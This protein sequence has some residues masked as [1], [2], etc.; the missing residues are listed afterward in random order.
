MISKYLA[1]TLAAA[2]L[3]TGLTALPA[4]AATVAPTVGPSATPSSS[5]ATKSSEPNAPQENTTPTPEPLPTEI[6]AP[7]ALKETQ[8]TGQLQGVGFSLPKRNGI[9][10]RGTLSVNPEKPTREYRIESYDSISGRWFTYSRSI[11]DQQGNWTNSVKSTSDDVQILRI[12]VPEAD[13]AYGAYTGPAT[14]I[15]RTKDIPTVTPKS[16][17]DTVVSVP[18]EQKYFK[19]KIDKG[20][21][22]T[23]VQLQNKVGTKWVKISSLTTSSGIWE[24]QFRLPLGNKNSAD[25]TQGYRIALDSSTYFDGATSKQINVR[26]ENPNRYTGTAKKVYGYTGSRCP[27]VLIRMDGS[28]HKNGAWGRAEMTSDPGVIRISTQVPSKYLRDV[29][30]HECSHFI[31]YRTATNSN[32]AGW[33]DYKA[34]A[35]KL[36][37]TSGELGMER[38]NECMTATWGSHSYWTYGAT[39]KLCGQAKVN[40]FVQKSLKGQKVA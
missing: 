31:Q 4:Q 28:I 22:G 12:V 18:W 17:P 33:A 37:G 27:A 2:V 11:T 20:S 40:D 21:T 16:T 1:P 15:K 8:G 35:N 3:L 14:T 13:G 7:V 38:V 19:F 36:M 9:A 6:P 29:S 23:Q 32:N 39:A 25:T 10:I 30:L 26:W 5:T 34:K 24:Y